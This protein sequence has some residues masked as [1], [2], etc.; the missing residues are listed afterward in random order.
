MTP[1]LLSSRISDQRFQKASYF[2]FGDFNFRLDS[3]S[4]VEVG[5]VR[6]HAR[7]VVLCKQQSRR[8]STGTFPPSRSLVC[9]PQERPVKKAAV[10]LGGI[11]KRGQEA[12]VRIRLVSSSCPAPPH[13]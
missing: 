10:S 4:V 5:P 7:S 11:T 9:L 8:P 2:V 1:S 12:A 3:K 13:P 6:G